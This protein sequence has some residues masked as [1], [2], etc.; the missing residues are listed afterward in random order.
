M[1][2]N[3]DVKEDLQLPVDEWLS[4]VKARILEIFNDGKKECLVSVIAAMGDEKI[5]SVKEGKD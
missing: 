5:V 3:G 2:E 1:T 4:D